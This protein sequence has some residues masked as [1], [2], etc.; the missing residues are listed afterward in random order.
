MLVLELLVPAILFLTICDDRFKPGK[1]QSKHEPL[2]LTRFDLTKKAIA[3]YPSNQPHMITWMKGLETLYDE[4][5]T[6]D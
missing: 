6:T 2:N 4:K 3:Y 1:M 5:P